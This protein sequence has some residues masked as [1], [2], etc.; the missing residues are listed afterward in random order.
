M[1]VQGM[2]VN[3]VE[4]CEVPFLRD[5]KWYID[6]TEKSSEWI[7]ELGKICDGETLRLT[8]VNE[9]GI[10]S[11]TDFQLLVGTLAKT[12]VGTYILGRSLTNKSFKKQA[13]LLYKGEI[14]MILL[15]KNILNRFTGF[16]GDPDDTD[17]KFFNFSKSNIFTALFLN[18]NDGYD[19][20]D[21]LEILNMEGELDDS[22]FADSL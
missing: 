17:N 22:G 5:F 20:A 7:D 6:Y 4:W 19:D 3:E 10:E 21:Y 2:D 14:C 12:V 18:A 15:Y 1:I 9:L 11:E 8:L 16:I 13:V